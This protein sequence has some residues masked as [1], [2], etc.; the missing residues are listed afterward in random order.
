MFSQLTQPIFQQL[1]A[2]IQAN[3]E[4]LTMDE[5]NNKIKH[6]MEIPMLA[7]KAKQELN[8][9]VMQPAEIVNN[10]YH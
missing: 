3:S 7:N 5:F 9:L 8:T 4:N 1:D 10:Y 6:Y 2:W